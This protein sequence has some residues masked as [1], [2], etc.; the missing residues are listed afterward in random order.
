MHTMHD[1]KYLN[2]PVVGHDGSVVGLVDVMLIINSL[3]NGPG[4]DLFW[5]VGAEDDDTE[6][7]TTSVHSSV[8][9]SVRSKMAAGAPSVRSVKSAVAQ[10]A[11]VKKDS[12]PVSKLRPT[13]PITLSDSSSILQVA[14]AMAAKRS[15]AALLVDAN[16]GLSGI[17]TDNDITR[18]VVAAFKDTSTEVSGVMTKNPKCVASSDSAIEALTVM[19]EN[20]FRHLPVVDKSGGIVGVLDIAKCLFDVIHRME[21]V[22][23]KKVGSGSG[24]VND[25]L[26]ASLRSS[27]TGANSAQLAMM[28]QM[29]GPMM[30]QMF[31]SS[32]VPTL[33]KLLA[34]A[35][36]RVAMVKP[37]MTVR[38]AGAVMAEHRK[39][40]L[41]VDEGALVGIFTPKD[42]LGRVVAKEL[43]L[44]SAL[45]S[46]VM[47]PSPDTLPD[48]AT[49]R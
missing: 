38:E 41:V 27:G 23:A 20:H 11:A 17:L 35:G 25:A 37:G 13:P 31:G 43:P 28:Q 34:D 40:V 4:A 22:A 8:A 9:P 2:L 47:T 39:A 48:T 5:G 12:R 14:Q 44:D 24:S 19:V 49:V 45:V 33:S 10:K 30:E 6:S 21:K 46:E 1:G 7:E 32:G 29:L 15:D 26:A 36:G 18:R 16:K 42:M 3:M